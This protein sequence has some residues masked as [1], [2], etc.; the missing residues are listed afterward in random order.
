[1]LIAKTNQGELVNLLHQTKEEITKLGKGG[2]RCP[3]C[4]Q[5]VMVKNGPV[6][7]SHFA[8]HTNSLC[9]NFSE[10]E[11]AEHLNGKAFLAKWCERFAIP[12]ELEAYLPALKQRPDLLINGN[13]AIEFQCSQLSLSRFSERTETYRRHGFHVIWIVGKQFFVNKSITA[14]QRGCLNYHLNCGFYFWELDVSQEKISCLM[15]IEKVQETGEIF[16]TKKSWKLAETSLLNVLAFPMKGQLFIRRHY[17]SLSLLLKT[18]VAIER[19]LVKRDP[20]TMRTQELLYRQ[21]AHMRALDICLFLPV[22]TPLLAKDSVF[23]WRLLVWRILE[24]EMTLTLEDLKQHFHR[25][26]R[27]G[28]IQCYLMPLV[29]LE[30]HLTLFLKEYLQSL[31]QLGYIGIKGQQLTVI[32]NLRT[33]SNG[34]QREAAAVKLL[35][36]YNHISA[37]PHKN[38]L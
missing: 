10:G 30:T 19:K 29:E 28:N 18:F 33:Y 20:M 8:H 9:Q 3:S 25:A 35:A 38:M 5:P 15:H 31:C 14:F 7:M 26:F 16:Y 36:T 17:T 2:W 1:M 32:R 12:Y 21:G 24:A 22:T 23:L 11:T 13:V 4:E 37:T 34:T 6:K 27:Q